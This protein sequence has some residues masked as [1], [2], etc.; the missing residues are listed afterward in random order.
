MGDS[1]HWQ[2]IQLYAWGI[3]FNIVGMLV[4]NS[5]AVVER[6]FFDGYNMWACTV[7][8]NNAL[9]GLAISAILKYADNIARVYAHASAMLVTMVISIFLFGQSPTPQLL[10][11]IGV[12]SAS[13]VQY[14]LKPEHIFEDSRYARNPEMKVVAPESQRYEPEAHDKTF[15]KDQED[16]N[17]MHK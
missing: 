17:L 15:N 6:G 7:V 13:A 1:I 11:A 4:N 10:I 9:N 12:V 2:N 14:N 5:S 16:G 8:I 3:L